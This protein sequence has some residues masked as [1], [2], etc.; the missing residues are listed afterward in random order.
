[1]E[2]QWCWHA[3][4]SQQRLVSWEDPEMSQR[5]DLLTSYATADGS[6]IRRSPVE[7]GRFFF[8]IIYQVSYIPGG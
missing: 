6:E 7:V 3:S 1:M 5:V 4:A 2:T 8:P